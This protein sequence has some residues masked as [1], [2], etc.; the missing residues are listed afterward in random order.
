MN[1]YHLEKLLSRILPRN[2][3]AIA[4]AVLIAVLAAISQQGVGNTDRSPKVPPGEVP[5]RVAGT[6]R[7]VDGDSFFISGDKALGE[8][9]LVGIDAPEGKQDCERNGKTWP[10]GRQSH[11]A[12]EQLIGR[13]AVDCKVEEADQHGR[14]LSVCSVAGTELNRWMVE[15]GWAVAYGRYRAEEARAKNQKLGLWSGTFE[16]PRAWRDRNNR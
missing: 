9:R 4:A 1:R 6:V 3:A 13:R 14:L 15:N 8:V 7:L 11:K 5:D 12:L 2:L 10:C 16:Q